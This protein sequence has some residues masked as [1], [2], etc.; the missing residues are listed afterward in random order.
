MACC[1]SS[2]AA[3]SVLAKTERDA[4]MVGLADLHPGYG[5]EEN[6]GYST[7]THLDALRRLGPSVHHRQSWRLPELAGPDCDPRHSRGVLPDRPPPARPR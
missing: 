1:C 6:K 5:W 3:A 7:A 2:V 4:I